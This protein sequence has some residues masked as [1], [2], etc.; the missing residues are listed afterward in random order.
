[1]INYCISEAEARRYEKI[2][3]K[4]CEKACTESTSGATRFK[5][6]V[7]V[8]LRAQGEVSYAGPI[9]RSRV[10]ATWR[11]ARHRRPILAVSRARRRGPG[12]ALASWWGRDLVSYRSPALERSCQIGFGQKCT[13]NLAS[14]RIHR[15]RPINFAFCLPKSV[16]R[17]RNTKCECG[18]ERSASIRHGG[19]ASYFENHT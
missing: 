5:G 15:F 13:A 1:M 10:W 12:A 7:V 2:I 18:S 4:L 14:G 6:A 3:L 19:R 16:A 11:T 17:S 8:W 9:G